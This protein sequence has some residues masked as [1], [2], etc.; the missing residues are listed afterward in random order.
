MISDAKFVSPTKRYAFSV[1][2]W[3][4]RM[5]HWIDSF[6]LCEVASG[7]VVFSPADSNWSLDGASW[8]GESTVLLSLRRYPGDHSPSI[9]EVTVDCDARTA[10]LKG[11]PAIPLPA[12]DSALEELYRGSPGA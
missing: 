2:P 5:S 6:A 8:L 11:R 1:S 3:E 4:A 10:E 12:L 9:F 7:A